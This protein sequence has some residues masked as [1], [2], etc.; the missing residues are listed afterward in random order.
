MAMDQKEQYRQDG[1]AME[2]NA[3][4][5]AFFASLAEQDGD[6]AGAEQARHDENCLNRWAGLNRQLATA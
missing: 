2:R 4:I 1:E 6:Q 5:A 3:N